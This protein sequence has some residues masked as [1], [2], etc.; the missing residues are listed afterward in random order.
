MPK[1]ML[2]SAE[3]NDH[4]IRDTAYGMV[5]WEEFCSMNDVNRD[6]K[7]LQDFDEI[8]SVTYYHFWN[9]NDKNY[10]DFNQSFDM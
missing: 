3:T 4:L 5:L 8:I 10:V 2:T 9:P 1:E 7:R 6:N